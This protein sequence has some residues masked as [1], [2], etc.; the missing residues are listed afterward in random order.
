[1]ENQRKPIPDERFNEPVEDTEG[2]ESEALS[3]WLY[4]D[5]GGLPIVLHADGR[6]TC[7]GLRN[8]NLLED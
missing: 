6:V 5:F 8:L 1:M 7:G 2:Y 3:D 4:E